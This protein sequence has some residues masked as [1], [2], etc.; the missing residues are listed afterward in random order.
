ML[1]LEALGSAKGLS[2][3]LGEAFPNTAFT[4]PVHGSPCLFTKIVV[5]KK[6]SVNW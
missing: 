5:V 6:E 2:C 3:R 4:S 1:H